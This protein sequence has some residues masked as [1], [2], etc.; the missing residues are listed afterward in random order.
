VSDKALTPDRFT[1]K[2]MAGRLS[3]QD[4]SWSGHAR[5]RQSLANATKR[6]ARE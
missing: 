3:E 5:H 4:G 6:L 1:M 2:T